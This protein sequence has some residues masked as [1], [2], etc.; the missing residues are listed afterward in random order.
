MCYIYTLLYVYVYVY[1]YIYIYIINLYI[2]VSDKWLPRVA[3]EPFCGAGLARG[4]VETASIIMCMYVC[5]Y[6]C[7]YIYIYINT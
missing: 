6:K 2:V 3:R 1:I 4:S 5:I 7:I